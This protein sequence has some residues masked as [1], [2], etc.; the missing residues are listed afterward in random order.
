[1]SESEVGNRRP[2]RVE[3]VRV[4]PLADGFVGICCDVEWDDSWRGVP[5]IAD[6]ANHDAVWLFAKYKRNARIEWPFE[7]WKRFVEGTLEDV[8]PQKLLE[9]LLELAPPIAAQMHPYITMPYDAAYD[10]KRRKLTVVPRL[11]AGQVGE[12]FLNLSREEQP[13]FTWTARTSREGYVDVYFEDYVHGWEHVPLHQ[14]PDKHK[15][16]AGCAIGTVDDMRGVMLYR[17]SENTGRGTV[18]FEGI[19]LALGLPLPADDRVKGTLSVWL[20]GL[21]MVHVPEGAYLLGSSRGV[22]GEYNC[23]YDARTPDK[24]F[25]VESE[26]AITVIENEGGEAVE[27]D[28]PVM[29]WDNS[30]QF[31]Y[32]GDIPAAFPKGHGGFYCMRTSL[33]Q[34]EYADF[35]NSLA[36]EAKTVRYPYLG[37]NSFRFAIYRGH[38]R[39]VAARPLRGCNYLGWAD[40]RAYLFWAGLRPM[41]EMEFEKCCRGPLAPVRGEYAWGTRK[42]ER[43]KTIVGDEASGTEAL[44]GNIHAGNGDIT[45]QGGD[46]GNGPVRAMAFAAP[47]RPNAEWL[48]PSSSATTNVETWQNTGEM[49]EREAMGATYWGVLGM[50]GNLWEYVVT[51]GTSDGRKFCGN[52]GSGA[53][54]ATGLP[55]TKIQPPGWKPPSERTPYA[56][57]EDDARGVGFR[58]GAFYPPIERSRVSDRWYGS[59]LSGYNARSMDTGCR[60][61]RSNPDRTSED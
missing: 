4:G 49:S 19:E 15:V 41:T 17:S 35:I 60:G 11:E 37:E 50:S 54:T 53:L 31:G 10:E 9:L 29:S 16:P 26:A 52:H 22:K 45:L 13:R 30:R 36:G 28:T 7:D 3:N 58:G 21:R 32:H 6:G 44:D 40:A 51:A 39:R 2:V 34:G 57:P 23:F 24:P 46:G 1:L 56:W 59:G 61:V 18:R 20:H 38:R 42:A 27:S 12:E 25:K 55:D 8:Q 43:I 48:F 33:T 5:E 47:G 14:S